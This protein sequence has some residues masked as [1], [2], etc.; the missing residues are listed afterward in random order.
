MNTAAEKRRLFIRRET[1]SIMG[2]RGKAL[3]VLTA[4]FL[5]AF[6][7]LVMSKASLEYLDE[8]M[9]DPFVSWIEVKMSNV[10][11]RSKYN[12]LFGELQEASSN[13]DYGIEGWTGAYGELWNV[14]PI[15]PGG[16]RLFK[17]R[18]FSIYRDSLLLAGLLEDNILDSMAFQERDFDQGVILSR[19]AA[20]GLTGRTDL[21]AA[22]GLAGQT[23]LVDKGFQYPVRIIAVVK[24]LPGGADIMCDHSLRRALNTGMD[25]RG[26]PL[27]KSKQST[28]SLA[29][30]AEEETLSLD[31]DALLDLLAQNDGWAELASE[32]DPTGARIEADSPFA[33]HNATITVDVSVPLEDIEDLRFLNRNWA[34]TMFDPFD[35][36]QVT[37]SGAMWILPTEYYPPNRKERFG[38]P[39]VG[40]KFSTLSL[41]LARLADA[42]RLREV[43][44]QRH[45]ISFNLDQIETQRNFHIFSAIARILV[46]ILT[47][48]SVVSVILYLSNLM[49]QHLQQV[50]AVLGTLMAFGLSNRD[51]LSIYM[52]IT[53]R[54]LLRASGA[55]LLLLYAAFAAGRGWTSTLDGP[56]AAVLQRTEV[57]SNGWVFLSLLVIFSIT[58]VSL[59]Q[60]L[61]QFLSQSPS[62]LLYDR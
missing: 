1:A 45:D 60:L 16:P 46:V 31:G 13:G 30:R 59:H 29:V 11:N 58:I 25:E 42:D 39:D 12:A 10:E 41:K 26:S 55:T 20:N 44:F 27:D 21:D 49:K 52:T 23:L 14:W 2:R 62:D 19:S 51:L 24:T 22:D 17:T 43:L 7:A 3:A 54:L 33:S 6:G 8:R 36:L 9:N 28:L 35:T 32:V 50:K 18:T 34:E 40:G 47:A 53:I 56:A 4:L 5:A 57:L 61:R 38:R 48:L 37:Y 15:E